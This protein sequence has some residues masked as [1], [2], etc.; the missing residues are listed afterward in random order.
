M[1]DNPAEPSGGIAPIGTRTL[2]GQVVDRL[3]DLIIT[4]QLEAG[5]RLTEMDLAKRLDVSRGPLREAIRDL[6]EAGLLDSQPY[7]GLYV[8][9]LTRRDLRELYSLR[10]NL[11]A[12]AFRAAW[13]RR[14][15]RNLTDLK[16]RLRR[17]H[18]A[19]DEGDDALSIR[20]EL[21]IHSWVFEYADHALLFEI[22]Q[23]MRPRLQTYFTWHHRANA[24][25][26]PLKRGNDRYVELATGDDLDAML[27][28]LED[29]MRQGLD[30][31]VSFL[32]QGEEEDAA[33]TEP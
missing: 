12:F 27:H 31:V 8:R 10:A 2:R 9:R 11:E 4:G 3:R 28:H 25:L 1:P 30:Q 20:R 23:R 32:N 19:I 7:K 15:R 29:H 18:D 6:V 21:D 33:A 22:W 5:R 26:L 14:D 24:D 17:F 13:D 16:D